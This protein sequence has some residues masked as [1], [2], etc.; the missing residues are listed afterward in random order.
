MKSTKGFKGNSY[1]WGKMEYARDISFTQVEKI[2]LWKM[3][4]KL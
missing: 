3:T 2:N 4:D 1:F